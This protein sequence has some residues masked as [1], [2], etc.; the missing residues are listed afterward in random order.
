[1]LRAYPHPYGSTPHALTTHGANCSPFSQP[2]LLTTADTR[3]LAPC[4]TVPLAPVGPRCRHGGGQRLRHETRLQSAVM[5]PHRPL[6]AV[7]RALGHTR[8][9]CWAMTRGA[10]S[11]QPGHAGA[12]PGASAPMH[13]DPSRETAR[14]TQC[15]APSCHERPSGGLWR[16]VRPSTQ[17]WRPVRV[18]W[19]MSSRCRSWPKDAYFAGQGQQARGGCG[20]QS[21]V[22]LTDPAPVMPHRRWP[23]QKACFC[24]MATT[25]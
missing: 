1:M 9:R 2:Y 13:A 21:P 3:N 19:D 5:L 23:G 17:I 25:T 18:I 20:C 4:P 6:T 12:S 8:W 22:S 14:L 15:L 10:R 24:V 16:R 7:A 11:T